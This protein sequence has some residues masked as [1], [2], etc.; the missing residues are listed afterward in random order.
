MSTGGK[1]VFTSPHVVA[2]TLCFEIGLSFLD[3]IV[4]SATCNTVGKTTANPPLHH[5]REGK[6]GTP[7]LVEGKGICS[8]AGGWSQFKWLFRDRSISFTCGYDAKPIYCFPGGA[9]DS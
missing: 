4:S 2:Q 3:T 8:F 7:V 6:E 1:V 9:E 5:E